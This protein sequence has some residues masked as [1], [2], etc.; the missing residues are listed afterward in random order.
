MASGQ[1]ERSGSRSHDLHGVN[2]A[3]FQLS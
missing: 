2:V 3:L 1:F